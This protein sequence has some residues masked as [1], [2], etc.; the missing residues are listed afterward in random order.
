MKDKKITKELILYFVITIVVTWTLWVPSILNSMEIKVPIILLIISMMASFTPSITG[1]VLHRKYLGPASFKKDMKKHLN[2][3]FS[4]VWLIG[5][6]VFFIGIAGLTYVMT[7]ILVEDFEPVNTVPWLMTPLLFI[8]ILLIGGA[9]GEEFGWRGFAYKRMYKVMPP[10]MATLIL[11][12]IWS[13]WHLPLFYMEGTVQ[14]SMPIW[15]FLL[16]N[17][18]LAFFYTWLYHRTRGNLWLMIY[19]HAVANTSAALFPYW[20]HNTGRLLGFGLLAIG[21]I[22]LYIIKPLQISNVEIE[23]D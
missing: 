15:Q 22:A 1:L 5:I 10:L 13:L 8:Q 4:K 16:Q 18:L 9:L 19:L 14:S 21:C 2:L 20:Q 6:P 3:K 7:L 11:G 12:I 23:K 17:T